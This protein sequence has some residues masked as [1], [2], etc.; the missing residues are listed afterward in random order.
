MFVQD[1]YFVTIMWRYS[2]MFTDIDVNFSSDNSFWSRYVYTKRNLLE[3]S[4]M[5]TF[6]PFK[7]NVASTKVK[8]MFLFFESILKVYH[9]SSHS[10]HS[11]HSLHS[12]HNSPH[13]YLDSSH[14]HHDSSDSHPD[15]L[16]SHLGSPHS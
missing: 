4:L 12:H 1:A 13:F 2:E 3:L 9:D 10:H 7:K 14:S 11:L 5:Y 8:L 15:S 16:H 6:A